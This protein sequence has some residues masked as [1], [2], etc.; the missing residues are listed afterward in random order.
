MFLTYRYFSGVNNKNNSNQFCQYIAVGGA[1][2]SQIDG[3]EFPCQRQK[4]DP[5]L[6]GNKGHVLGIES[7][8]NYVIIII[9]DNFLAGVSEL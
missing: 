3:Y 2:A 5:I 4:G 7:I 6:C 9:P 1:D 8:A